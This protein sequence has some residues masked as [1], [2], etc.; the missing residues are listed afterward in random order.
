MKS[1][2][3]ASSSLSSPKAFSSE[4]KGGA[5]NVSASPRQARKDAQASTRQTALQEAR[6][7]EPAAFSEMF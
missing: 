3:L 7:P 2:A 6:R 5:E 4:T 1:N